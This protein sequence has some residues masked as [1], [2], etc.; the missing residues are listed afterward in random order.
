MSTEKGIRKDNCLI[1]VNKRQNFVHQPT[2]VSHQSNKRQ[3]FNMHQP[4]HLNQTQS[5]FKNTIII[6]F[7]S[8][9]KKNAFIS[10]PGFKHW[11]TYV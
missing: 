8:E 3:K 9:R 7:L 11:R 4:T 2:S 6:H 10:Y 1:K 5:F